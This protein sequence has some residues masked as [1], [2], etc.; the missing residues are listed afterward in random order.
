[1]EDF[2]HTRHMSSETDERAKQVAHQ[3][4]IKGFRRE[5]EEFN[6]SHLLYGDDH[7]E[8]DHDKPPRS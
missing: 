2:Q 7:I 3:R 6:R 8:K 5:E 4:L 1:M